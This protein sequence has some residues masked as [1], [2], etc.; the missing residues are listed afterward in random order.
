MTAHEFAHQWWPH[1]ML[2][3]ETEGYT[4]FVVALAQYSAHMVL[5]K[6]RGEDQTRRYLQFELHRYLQGRAWEKEEPPLARVL[7]QSYLAYRKGAMVMNLLAKRLGE[8][9]VNRALRSL[10]AQHK[11]KDVPYPRTLDLIAALR[12]EAH[13][14]DEQALITD[15]FERITLYD[16]RVTKPTAVQRADGKWDVTVPVEARKI[17]SD[18][19]GGE[20]ETPL[21][22]RIEIGLFTAEPGRDAFKHSNVIMMERHPIHSGAQTLKFVTD[23][24]PLFAGVDPYNFY[25]DRNSGD[26]VSAVN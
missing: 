21:A 9:A 23:K 25:I 2:A 11:F 5:K 3:A 19:K 12:A 6:V 1:Q 4:V 22:E 20:T 8:D 7:G 17:Y 15:L 24:K 16:L 26:N 13:S 10:L 18:G 14:P